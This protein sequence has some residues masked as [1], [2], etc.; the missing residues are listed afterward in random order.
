M[1]YIFKSNLPV[2]LLFEDTVQH[3]AISIKK[4]TQKAEK[5]GTQPIYA[6]F[7][8]TVSISISLV[9]VLE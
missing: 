7:R 6:S 5:F 3:H 8:S 9:Q 1:A 2:Q 4:N